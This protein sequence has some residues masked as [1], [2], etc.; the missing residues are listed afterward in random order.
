[1]KV[2]YNVA[3]DDEVP[4][5]GYTEYEYQDGVLMTRDEGEE[6]WSESIH[7]TKQDVRDFINKRRDWCKILEDDGEA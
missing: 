2:Y 5:V 7:N 1:M 4:S 3:D 6:E